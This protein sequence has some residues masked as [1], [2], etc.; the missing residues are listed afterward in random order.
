MRWRELVSVPAGT[1]PEG[2][3]RKTNP[4]RRDAHSENLEENSDMV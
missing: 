4:N 2:Y 3:R 1:V